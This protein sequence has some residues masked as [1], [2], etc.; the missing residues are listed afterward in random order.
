MS[1]L[2][3]SP[4]CISHKGGGPTGLWAISIGVARPRLISEAVAIGFVAQIRGERARFRRVAQESEPRFSE[5]LA[6]A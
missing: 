6:G 4:Q 1:L 3:P 5:R 2:E